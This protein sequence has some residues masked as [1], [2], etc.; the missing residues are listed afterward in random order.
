[1][2]AKHELNSAHFLGALL[3]AGLVGGLTGSFVVFGVALVALLVAGY[4]TGD[5]RR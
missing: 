3:V 1:V 4:H 5:I 2:S